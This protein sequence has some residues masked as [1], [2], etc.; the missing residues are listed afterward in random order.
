MK[1]Y[2]KTHIY[3]IFKSQPNLNYEETTK[4]T[5]IIRKYPS[6][7]PL[8]LFIESEKNTAV[9]ESSASEAEIDSG[10]ESED[11]GILEVSGEDSS[12]EEEEEVSGGRC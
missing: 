12:E 2:F 10:G 3:I 8:L 11:E 6:P 5:I 7:S 9:E 1:T 4:I